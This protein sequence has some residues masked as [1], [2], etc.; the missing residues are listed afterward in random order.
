MEQNRNIY[1]LCD[2]QCVLSPQMQ[3]GVEYDPF[4]A[5]CDKSLAFIREFTGS[6]YKLSHVCCVGCSGR[7][8]E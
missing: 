3:N 2:Q 5:V 1:T 8:S 6:V 7:G 4:S